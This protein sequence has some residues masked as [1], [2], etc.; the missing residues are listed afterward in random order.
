MEKN[1]YNNFFERFLEELEKEISNKQFEKMLEQEQKIDN[2]YYKKAIYIQELK[3]I[4]NEY[5]NLE[6]YENNKTKIF[7]LLPGNPEIVFRL[8][9]ECV[10]K[11]IDV[12][13]GMEDFCLAQN[14]LLI[15]TIKNVFEKLRIKNKIE[16]KN[17]ISDQEI[18]GISKNVEKTVIIGNSNLYNRL[19]E[20]IDVKLNPYGIFEIY[21]DSEDFE[22]LQ[23]MIFEIFSQNQFEVEFFDDLDFDDAVRIINKNGYKFCSILF[24][25][26]EVKIR[27]FKEKIDAK[28]V[29]TNENPFKK[30]KFTLEI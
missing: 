15:E 3:K 26:D 19:K 6:K 14:T 2:K 16:L 23:E 12:I 28:F 7:I 10:R 22:E 20:K 5:K 11:N 4:I 9:I 17:L 27:Q 18:I 25:N 8:G 24:T 29:L 13:I 21:S 1:S 30:I